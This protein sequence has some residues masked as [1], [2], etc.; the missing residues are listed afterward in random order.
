[1]AKSIDEILPQCTVRISFASKMG[2]GFFVA[3]GLILT[4]AHVL[5]DKPINSS[6]IK[7]A[8]ILGESYTATLKEVYP[9]PYP[10]LAIIEIE[11]NTNP[12]V[13]LISDIKID[14]DLYSFGFTDEYPNGDSALFVYEGPSYAPFLLKLKQSQAR[15]G[16]SGAPLLNLRTGGICGVVKKTRDRTSDLG[17]RAIPISVAMNEIKALK[18]IRSNQNNIYWI[19]ALNPQ[20][21]KSLGIIS[22]AMLDQLPNDLNELKSL[23][24]RL[25][26]AR[27]SLNI[28]ENQIA[29]YTNLT[30]PA[31][32]LIQ[33]EDKRQE[34]NNLETRIGLYK[35]Q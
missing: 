9:E 15:S 7:I 29:G 4:C 26:M 18:E 10:D 22:S 14:D 13:W 28:L 27:R 1:M 11:H 23:H 6:V 21:S 20:Q 12:Y 30:V 31:H 25:S 17:A 32:L 8:T 16:L 2:T 19:N 3:P 35:E 34:V 33:L 24:Q 5:A